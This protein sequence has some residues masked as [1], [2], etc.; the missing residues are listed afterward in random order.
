MRSEGARKRM[1]G[2][3][4]WRERWEGGA[5]GKGFGMREEFTFFLCEKPLVRIQCVL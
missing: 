5:A 4:G 1:W 2:A 3:M